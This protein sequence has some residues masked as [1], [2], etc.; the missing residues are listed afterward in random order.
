MPWQSRVLRVL[1][2]EYAICRFS[3]GEEIPSWAFSAISD[4]VSVS[5]SRTE[6]SVI[7][8]ADAV[9]GALSDGISWRCM[10]VAGSSGLDEPGVLVSVADP[11]AAAGISVFV[12]ATYDTDYLLVTDI[13]AAMR[14]LRAAGHQVMLSDD[15]DARPV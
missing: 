8:A 15:D 11:L 5:R 12:I 4:F 14:A 1:P 10:H 6:L 13:E 2:E 3:P 7:C 9:P